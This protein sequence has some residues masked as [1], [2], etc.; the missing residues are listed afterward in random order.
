MSRVSVDE[1]R[2]LWLR[3]DDEE[4]RR[5]ASEMTRDGGATRDA[6]E[7]YWRA[8]FADGMPRLELPSDRP[9]PPA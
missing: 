2:E 5:R 6:A 3:G 9:R 1:A 8:L 4:L 7:A